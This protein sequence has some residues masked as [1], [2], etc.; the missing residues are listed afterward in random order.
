MNTIAPPASS[1]DRIRALQANPNATWLTFTSARG[2]EISL[3]IVLSD[4]TPRNLPVMDA[5][6]LVCQTLV[7]MGET[8]NWHVKSV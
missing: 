3:C 5:L 2:E 8:S 6:R 4:D 7:D 1:W